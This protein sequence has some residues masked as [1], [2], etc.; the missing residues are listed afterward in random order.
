M[1][2]LTVTLAVLITALA[3]NAASF[4]WTSG[5]IYGSDGA[6]KWAGEVVLHAYLAS[7]SADDAIV[8]ATF[9]PTTA[10]T[11]NFT[12]DN[13]ELVGGNLYSFFMTVVDSANNKMWT[14][15]IKQA[16]AN[17]TSTAAVAFGSQ[18]ASTQTASNWAPIPEPTSAFLLLLGL[19]G[20]A[21]KRKRA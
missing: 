20:L 15:D 3:T 5:N 4:K 1:K 19:G 12:F 21:L 7:G 16:T 2:K 6:T 10:G 14:S 17:A 9:T 18:A 13:D 8:A 11:V